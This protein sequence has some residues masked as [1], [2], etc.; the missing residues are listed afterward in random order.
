M[1]RYSL[2]RSMF[3]PARIAPHRCR[4]DIIMPFPVG[5]MELIVYAAV[6]TGL[7]FAAYHT[8][9]MDYLAYQ[10]DYIAF[11][12][13]WPSKPAD[14]KFDME[15]FLE[16]KRNLL[17]YATLEKS[18]M[19]NGTAL[20]ELKVAKLYKPLFTDIPKILLDKWVPDIE[21]FQGVEEFLNA[22]NFNGTIAEEFFY[23]EAP[24]FQ[25]EHHRMA[26]MFP[27]EIKGLLMTIKIG[28]C[29][30]WST[31]H[32]TE[33]ELRDGDMHVLDVLET[34]DGQWNISRAYYVPAYELL[35]V[36]F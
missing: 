2:I 32:H 8:T 6:V 33:L 12:T 26:I 19:Q 28:N 20:H 14:F 36:R 7:I 21:R 25:F 17:E 18:L 9:L 15:V 11:T 22:T 16:H 1:S 13:A 30:F 4:R 23:L 3:R 29:Y 24:F 10:R 34:E 31:C 5:R 35:K 27:T